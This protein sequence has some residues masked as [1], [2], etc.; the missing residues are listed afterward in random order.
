MVK[1]A[2]WIV[3]IA[4]LMFAVCILFWSISV[5]NGTEDILIGNRKG[6]FC[7]RT[8]SWSGVAYLRRGGGWVIHL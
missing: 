3:F 5:W 6:V 7:R 8:M 4:L 1:G 2:G